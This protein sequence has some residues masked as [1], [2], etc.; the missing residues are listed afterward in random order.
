[1]RGPADLQRRFYDMLMESQYWPADRLRDYQ[2]SQLAQ[3]LR[4]AKTQVPFYATRL[5]AVLKPNGDIDWDRWNEI[6][7]V[8]RR[9]L[10]DH[11]AAMQASRL[12]VGHG[13]VRTF[14]TSGSTGLPIE[15]NNTSIA[16]IADNGTRWRAQRRHQ[17]DWSAVLVSRLGQRPIAEDPPNG[18]DAGAWGPPWEETARHGRL[19][20]IT[21]ERPTADVLDV[22]ERY[23]AKYLIA[24]PNMVH[25][26]AIEA[27]Q[28]GRATRISAVLTQG[29]AVHGDDRD[30]CR[31]VFG[32]DII[33]LYSSK[34]GGQ[35]AHPCEHG[36]L[37]VN[38]ECCLVELVDDDDQ[39]VPAGVLGHV[40][41]T[42][43]FQ[44]AQPR[45]RYRQGDLAIAGEGCPCGRH[46]PVLVGVVGRTNGIFRHPDGRA[47]S[48]QLPLSTKEQLQA[49]FWQLA[50]IGPNDYEMRYVPKDRSA[51][52][53]EAATER[54]FRRVYFADASLRFVRVD[55]LPQMRI[56][57]LAEYVN[58][59]KTPTV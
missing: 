43:F 42:P 27:E 5:D 3:L 9:D 2:R 41:V 40:V 52:G 56:G 26:N 51:F 12:M 14:E 24:A 17:L 21:R 28:L 57:K 6:P 30:I 31:R 59:W 50:Q 22:L 53:D 7:I 29:A 33:E 55:E 38:S 20:T 37:H 15:V 39:P 46:S 34:E 49:E 13:P 11:R 36:R 19:V 45:I 25:V 32:A 16:I 47:I 23:R 48:Q 35:M 8:N 4:H 10:I 58:E 44:T 18:T 1:M 54:D